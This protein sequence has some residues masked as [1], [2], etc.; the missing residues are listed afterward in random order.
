MGGDDSN[1]NEGPQWALICLVAFDP[2]LLL[3]EQSR[4]LRWRLS[5]KWAGIILESPQSTVTQKLMTLSDRQA[6]QE[7]KEGMRVQEGRTGGPGQDS[8]LGWERGRLELALRGLWLG[9]CVR[10]LTCCQRV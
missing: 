6:D 9:L 8:D 5:V 7:R 1:S 4:G 2:Q 10:A 3:Y